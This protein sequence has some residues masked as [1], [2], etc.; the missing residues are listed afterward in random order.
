MHKKSQITFTFKMAQGRVSIHG[1][2][3]EAGRGGEKSAHAEGRAVTSERHENPQAAHRCQAA[4]AALARPGGAIQQ[5]RTVQAPCA[6]QPPQTWPLQ[7]AVG[8][9]MLCQASV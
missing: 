6:S 1:A 8:M 5:L 4:I 2:M 9:P 7:S 3:D